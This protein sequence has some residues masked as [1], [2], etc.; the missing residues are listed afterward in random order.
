MI[1]Q[2]SIEAYTRIREEGLLSRRRFQ[3]YEYVFANGPCTARQ[4]ALALLK[5]GIY[6]SSFQARFS[7]LRAAGVLDEVGT[8]VDRD[9]GQRA[10][11]WDVTAAVPSARPKPTQIKCPTCHGRGHLIQERLL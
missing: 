2:T 9:T 7:E 4:A 6:P 3:V 11:L 5:P 1:R 10:I 8:T